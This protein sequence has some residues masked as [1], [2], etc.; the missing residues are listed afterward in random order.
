MPFGIITGTLVVVVAPRVYRRSQPAVKWYVE[1]WARLAAEAQA[2]VT[3]QPEVTAAEVCA[4]L[5]T[6]KVVSDV[7]GRLRLRVAHLRGCSRLAAEVEECLSRLPAVR[8]VT[9][10][11]ATGSVLVYY[12]SS[13]S[14]EI[15]ALMAAADCSCASSMR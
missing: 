10:S 2:S 5:A 4:G 15:L 6:A 7:P 11:A 12:S 1:Q 8:R 13:A 3:R 9:T 14:S